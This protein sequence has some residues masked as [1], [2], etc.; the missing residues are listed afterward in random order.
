LGFIALIMA[1][2]LEQIRPLSRGNLGHWAYDKVQSQL[3]VNTQT[4]ERR[5][6]VFAWSAL[7]VGMAVLCALLDW[8]AGR[9]HPFA[10][11]VLHVCALYLTVG[12]RQF[13]HAFSE[14]RVALVANDVDGAKL[15]LEKWLRRSD[16]Q[17]QAPRGNSPAQ[18][19]EVCR[20]AISHA[21]IDSHRFVLAPLLWYVLLPG[22]LGP[23]VYRCAE[24]LSRDWGSD[25]GRAMSPEHADVA[26]K[27]YGIIDWIP[28]RL[29]AAAFA[30]VGNFEDA[31]YCWRRAVS[32]LPEDPVMAQQ[33]LILSSG[34]GALGYRI[35]DSVQSAQWRGG[36]ETLPGEET[37]D[38]EGQAPD[39]AAL[40]SA[41]GLVWRTVVLWIGI[42]G[43]LTA[44]GWLGGIS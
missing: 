20:L 16:E 6:A 25:R 24:Y 4:G 14:I 41:V 34:S 9:L 18:R 42:F 40:Q 7:I 30:V 5:L 2:V 35:Y 13:S 21:M 38:W 12:F 32:T 28:V 11:L 43:L 19:S 26:R 39:A 3:H 15:I 33:N 27:G 37:F 36:E 10:Q 23:V 1:L 8:L 44:A 31:I 17:F 22:F 29:S